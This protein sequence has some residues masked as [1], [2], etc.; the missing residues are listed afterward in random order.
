MRN[1][2]LLL[3]GIMTAGTVAAQSRYDPSPRKDL[4]E[5]QD[6]LQSKCMSFQYINNHKPP[7]IRVAP[8]YTTRV[9]FPRELKRCEADTKTLE[10]SAVI[11]QG[12]EQ[13]LVDARKVTVPFTEARVRVADAETTGNVF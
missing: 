11:E 13:E 8:R 4:E 9:K 12:G 7:K 1:K 2:I 5:N 6:C 3:V 10:I